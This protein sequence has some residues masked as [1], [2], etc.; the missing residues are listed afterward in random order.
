MPRPA[1]TRNRWR[2][3]DRREWF[4]FNRKSVTPAAVSSGTSSIV[5]PQSTAPCWSST[6]GSTPT[7]SSV[8]GSRPNAARPSR[9][10]DDPRPD[11]DARRAPRD[12]STTEP[13]DTAN[14][15][16]VH[17]AA[18]PDR[19]AT[20]LRRLRHHVDLLESQQRRIECG[21]RFTPQRLAHL[22]GV[23][24]ESCRDPRTRARQPRTPRAANRRRHQ[25]RCVRSTTRRA[26]T[27]SWP[28]RPVVAARQ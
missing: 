28:T 18:D 17:R 5:R 13:G 16:L 12:P 19:H 22:E 27:T 20:G 10:C 15:V 26:S 23:I 21:A 2:R 1:P 3:P 14:H 25:D 24:E 8:D 6:I 7:M 11:V 9:I 4:V